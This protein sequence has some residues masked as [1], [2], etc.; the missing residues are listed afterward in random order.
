MIASLNN[1][2]TEKEIIKQPQRAEAED[3]IPEQPEV[4]L[5]PN[6]QEKV[7]IKFKNLDFMIVSAIIPADKL[8]NVALQVYE[9]LNQETKPN[10]KYCE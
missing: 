2:E 6:A 7:H 5:D 8:T 4:F 9:I 1:V 10:P 3:H